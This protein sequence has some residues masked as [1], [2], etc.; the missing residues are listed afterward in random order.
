MKS[1]P[2]KVT[3]KTGKV[4]RPRKNA[5]HKAARLEARA[6]RKAANEAARAPKP[7]EPLHSKSRGTSNS[8]TARR[9]V[10]WPDGTMEVGS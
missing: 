4:P 3:K 6:N 9:A 8:R 5:H 7:I 10:R 2:G 1:S